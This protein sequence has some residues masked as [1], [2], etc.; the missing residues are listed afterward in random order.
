MKKGLYS[1][2]P[3]MTIAQI[4]P[5]MFLFALVFRPEVLTAAQSG[6]AILLDPLVSAAVSVGAADTRGS[7]N[8][9]NSRGSQLPGSMAFCQLLRWRR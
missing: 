7:S 9:A 3:E 6:D 4:G 5:F 8:M 2:L 1:G